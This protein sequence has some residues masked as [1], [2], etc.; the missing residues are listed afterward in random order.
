MESLIVKTPETS[1]VKSFAQSDYPDYD[2]YK[3]QSAT[4]Y[5]D[6][7]FVAL[8]QGDI[9]HSDIVVMDMK[10]LELSVNTKG[11][12]WCID[13]ETNMIFFASNY[14]KGSYN[15]TAKQGY[16]DNFVRYFGW[17]VPEDLT[18]DH[19][20]DTLQCTCRIDL[21]YWNV[22]QGAYACN[23]KIFQYCTSE[24]GA[25]RDIDVGVW[26]ISESERQITNI[27]PIQRTYEPEGIAV[28]DDIIWLIDRG[29]DSKDHYMR[30][31]KLTNFVNQ[32]H[33]ANQ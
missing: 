1:I 8:E 7:M 11:A 18:L 21:P 12:N 3:V 16:I 30:I 4:V 15:A 6:Y 9:G 27:Y 5:N 17:P 28:Q 19:T 24:G 14:T 13:S 20:F 10:S 31:V 29:S 2:L 23:G 33:G 32:E 25:P 26:E 22:T